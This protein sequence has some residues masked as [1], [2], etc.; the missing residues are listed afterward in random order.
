M[1]VKSLTYILPEASWFSAVSDGIST[2]SGSTS[3][4]IT[5]SEFFKLSAGATIANFLAGGSIVAATGATSVLD[6]ISQGL[7]ICLW[8]LMDVMTLVGAPCG[9]STEILQVELYTIH[10][11]II[12]LF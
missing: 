7:V 11:E 8:E 2:V 10:L 1:S 4:V 5:S 3:T 9:F 12:F 6:E